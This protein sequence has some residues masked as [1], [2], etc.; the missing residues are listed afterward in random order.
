MDWESYRNT[1]RATLGDMR[2]TD[3]DGSE[4]EADSAFG[5]LAHWVRD[6]VSAR[7]RVYFVGNGAS[8]SMASHFSA[9]LAK[10]SGAATEVFTDPAL[11]TATGNDMGYAETFAFPLRQRMLPGEV[12]IAIS[13]SGNSL[14]AVRAVQAARELGGRTATFTAMLPDNAMRGLGDLNFYIPAATYGMAE[15]GHAA[16]LHHLIDSFT[17]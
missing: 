11:L 2:A 9:D 6:C 12:L 10:I 8:A 13:S 3:Q 4:L 7:R 5:R 14:N 17:D 15:S 16:M 1:L